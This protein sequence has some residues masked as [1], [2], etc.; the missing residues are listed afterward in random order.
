MS[1][2]FTAQ[3]ESFLLGCSWP[4]NVRELQHIIERAVV[5]GDGGKVLPDDLRIPES[6]RNVAEGT[7]L[8]SFVEQRTREHVVKVLDGCGWRK[9]RTAEALGVDRATLYRMMRKWDLQRT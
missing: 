8:A 9:G 7:N 6:P 1:C 3:A 5:L 2:I 4:G